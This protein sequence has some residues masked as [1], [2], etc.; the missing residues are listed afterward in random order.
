M[1][2][3]FLIS[4]GLTLLLE[5]GFALIWGVK[6]K[7]FLIILL[8]NCL[9]NPLVVLWHYIH[10]MDSLWMNTLFPEVA[11]IGAEMLILRKFSKTTPAPM[12]LGFF[13]NLFSYCMGGIILFFVQ[14]G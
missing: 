14:G 10:V 4:L 8:M 3:I 7:D 6:G 2:E 11:A 12:L 13:I 9:T 1:S 5:F